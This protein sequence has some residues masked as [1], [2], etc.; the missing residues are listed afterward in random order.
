MALSNW[1]ELG[2]LVG[3]VAAGLAVR[4]LVKRK[5]NSYDGFEGI[6][7]ERG[8]RP[9]RRKMDLDEEIEHLESILGRK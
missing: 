3:L 2:V 8:K 7:K 9:L 1:I 4:H 5:L 6:I